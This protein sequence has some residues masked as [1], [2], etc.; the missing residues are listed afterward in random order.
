MRV[1]NDIQKK[2]G[3]KLD[4]R[5]G[6]TGS[7]FDKLSMTARRDDMLRQAQHDKRGDDILRQAQNDMRRDDK[8]RHVLDLRKRPK[9][10]YV[11]EN[12]ELDRPKAVN[13][14]RRIFDVYSP[15]L[16]WEKWFKQDPMEG[17]WLKKKRTQE[18][19]RLA[20]AGAMIVLALNS[21][22]VYYRAL[23]V[24][25]EVVAAAYQG[26]DELMK[27]E[28]G[29]KN[30]D[31]QVVSSSLNKALKSFETAQ[32]Q[33]WFIENQKA[34]F[35]GDQGAS[36]S[37]Q[38][39]LDS[40]QN[41]AE[42]GIY[43]TEVVDSLSALTQDF[44]AK[45]EVD[46]RDRF[47]VKPGMT[48]A[49]AGMTS[50][51]K[52]KM[53]DDKL[54]MT[55]DKLRMTDDKLKMT[56][57]KLKMTND[58]LKM[59][60][61]GLKMTSTDKLKQELEKVELALGYLREAKE[62]LGKVNVLV[63]PKEVRP[64]LS[65]A[66]MKIDEVLETAETMKE[67][68]PAALKLLGDRYPYRYLILLQNN[69]EIR[70]TGGFI[71]SYI[72][73]DMNDGEMTNMEVHDIYERDG[74]LGAAIEAP[75]EIAR[76]GG[77]HW[78][79]RDANY[80]PDFEVSAKKVAWFLEKE[81]GPGV[82]VVMGVDLALAEKILEITGPVQL[83]GIEFNSDNFVT[84]LT[85]IV[86][87]KLEGE[88]NPKQILKDFIP[89]VETKLRENPN[90]WRALMVVLQDAIEEKHLQA[91]AKNEEVQNLFGEL[92]MTGLVKQPAEDEDYFSIIN[93]SIGGNKSD[94]WMEQAV[95][96]RTF[97]HEDGSVIDQ[98]TISRR[99]TWDTLTENTVLRY[100]AE[101][102]FHNVPGYLKDILGRYKNLVGMRIYVPK[103]TQ[104]LEV[105]GVDP[106]E[107]LVREDDDLGLTYFY[108]Q[109]GVFPQNE[110]KLTL[111]YR[112]PFKLDLKTADEYHLQ[113]QKQAGM[114]PEKWLKRIYLDP[115]VKEYRFYPLMDKIEDV[116]QKEIELVKD[117]EFAGLVGNL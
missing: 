93:T 46:T 49:E 28:P 40:G 6:Q 88:T 100:L 26:F 14:K 94:A 103:G 17:F 66:R 77:T 104:L 59:T 115:R 32:Q 101:A 47:L 108:T 27:I 72:L 85:Y 86:E 95:T 39:L 43:F 58:K 84:L 42:A 52:L 16:F 80:S 111:T 10:E 102:D 51:D 38:A 83:R 114:R 106:K 45:G 23:D 56:N 9:N 92:K 116:W 48:G 36:E 78:R 30:A 34:K 13:G 55:D 82:D 113:V 99:H 98:V 112:L 50:F 15:E 7:C 21:V 90:K 75:E 110:V 44:L 33:L 35:A 22:N 97:V 4:L 68:W 20:V 69:N 37:V 70:P 3:Q 109:V 91:Y 96:H 5:E 107:V 41:L 105:E 67:F 1:F 76:L 62:N 63:L 64:K 31:F 87:A 65:M 24:K 81:N 19:F 12:T 73:L 2:G 11:I 60:N 18:L 89:A 71:G 25:N 61:D 74:Q 79:M 57:D 117:E 29:V 8:S 53:T 54:K